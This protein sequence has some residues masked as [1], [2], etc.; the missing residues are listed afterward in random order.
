MRLV[1]LLTNVNFLILY[2]KMCQHLEDLYNQESLFFQMIKVVQYVNKIMQINPLKG[3][4]RTIDFGVT[5]YE[6]FN[7]MASD[8]TL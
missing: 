1:V 8:S 7:D 6:K 4:D 3:Q 2:T 5:E